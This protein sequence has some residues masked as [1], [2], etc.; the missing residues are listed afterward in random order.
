[1][2]RELELTGIGFAAC[3]RVMCNSL[4]LTCSALRKFT[5]AEIRRDP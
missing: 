4:N 1:L 3:A 2:A 5:V